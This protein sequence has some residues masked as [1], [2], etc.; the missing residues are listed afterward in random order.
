MSRRKSRIGLGLLEAFLALTAVVGAIFVLPTLPLDYIRGGPFP[1][2]IV[3]ALALGLLVGGSAV[4]AVLGLIVRPL[5]G[6]VA[7]VVAG[8][9]IIGFEVVEI[10]VV[11]FIR[12]GT[13]Q[14]WLQVVYITV[15]SVSVVLGA[16]LWL[17]LTAGV[18]RIS[19]RVSPGASD[20]TD[21][22]RWRTET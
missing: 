22:R 3:P 10:G 6:A 15:G 12:P 9:M 19:S 13:P 1:D 20:R 4:V 16:R 21:K 18:P 7:S 11:G 2:Y 8:M 17:A 14:A 5:I